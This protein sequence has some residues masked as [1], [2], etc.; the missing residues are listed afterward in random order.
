MTE[1]TVIVLHQIGSHGPSYWL[2]YPEDQRG[3]SRRPASRPS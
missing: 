3:L 2:R 1:D